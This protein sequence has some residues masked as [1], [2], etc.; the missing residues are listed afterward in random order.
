MT[1]P[2]IE[3]AL[4]LYDL[5]LAVL[6]AQADD[7]KSVEGVVANFGKWRRRLPRQKTEEL[8][9]RYPGANIAILPHLCR[10]RLVIAEC[11]NG[12]ALAAAERDYGP[13][14]LVVR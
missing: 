13:T 9:R 6:P 5:G 7:G 3:D 2:T 14:P 12:R 1:G 8:F 10:P 11:D 4:H